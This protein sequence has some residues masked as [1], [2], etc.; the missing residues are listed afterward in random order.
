MTCSGE[1][2][3]KFIR[4]CIPGAVGGVLMAAGD[5][6]LGCIPLQETDS[7]MFNR[8]FLSVR[9]LRIVEACPDRRTGRS[10]VLSL[11]LSGEGTECG[12]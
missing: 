11:L 3:E 5:W 10:R 2:S 7:G 8:A 6:L 12:F 1:E 4:W 9:R